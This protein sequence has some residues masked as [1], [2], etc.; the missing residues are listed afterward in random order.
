MK[1]KKRHV[2][3]NDVYDNNFL[4]CLKLNAAKE[5]EALASPSVTDCVTVYIYLFAHSQ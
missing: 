2:M 4:T 1:T 3:G 5:T